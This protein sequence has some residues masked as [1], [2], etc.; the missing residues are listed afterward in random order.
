M[1][2][3]VP[4][5]MGIGIMIEEL[6]ESKNVKVHLNIVLKLCLF[7]NFLTLLQHFIGLFSK[8][9]TGITQK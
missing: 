8:Y 3:S 5:V 6:M 2:D 7:E 1:H 9:E 4:S